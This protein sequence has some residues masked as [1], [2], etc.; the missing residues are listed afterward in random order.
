MNSHSHGLLLSDYENNTELNS[1]FQVL[2]TNI[3]PSN[4]AVFVS[5]MEAYSYPFY[6]TQWHPE[7]NNFEWSQSE[8]YTNIP[9][10]YNAIRASQATA[11]FLIQEARKSS[12]IFPEEE[13][14]KLIYSAP[15]L[16]T[17]PDWIYEQVYAFDRSKNELGATSGSMTRIKGF[18]S[19][20][21]LIPVLSMEPFY[22]LEL[23][24][25]G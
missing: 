10:S 3:A 2:S 5:T 16:Y 8:D 15:L 22:R 18:M 23:A 11:N 14:V 6:G 20:L 9:H 12:H 1:F 7:K 17:G 24:M 13:Q 21:S 19:L 25:R 4:G